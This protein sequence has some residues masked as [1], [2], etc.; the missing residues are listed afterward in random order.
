MTTTASHPSSAESMI[1]D[2]RVR[3]WKMSLHEAG[4]A[5]AGRH[6]L[7]RT[8]RA[9]VFGNGF[10]VV[11]LGGGT[12][13]PISFRE[14]KAAAAGKAAESLASQFDP[15][16]VQF[17]VLLLEETYP[18]TAGPL[19]ACVAKLMPDET[20]IA[21][22]CIQG[23]EG[24]PWLWAKRHRWVYSAAAE[25]VSEY[26]R[27]IVDIAA[28]LYERGVVTLETEPVRPAPTRCC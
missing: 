1:E 12:D 23:C 8:T 18:E 16:E 6:L 3:Q 9:A 19:V 5:V 24:Q 2:T 14:A 25:F 11:D 7:K 4:H 28:E 20:A 27:E 26:R 10:G 22:W 15:P 13:V 17:P 21:R